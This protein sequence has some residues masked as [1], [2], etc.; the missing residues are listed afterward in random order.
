MTER[1]RVRNW[2]AAGVVVGLPWACGG[3]QELAADGEVCYRDDDCQAGLVCVAPPASQDRRCTSDVSGLVSMVPG[4][5]PVPGTGG[6]AQA[7]APSTGSGG[8]PAAAGQP[9]PPGG[10]PGASSG[11]SPGAGGAP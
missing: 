11:G 10:T 4:P 6:S 5:E 1:C 8:A 3:P 7:G 2:I 9:E